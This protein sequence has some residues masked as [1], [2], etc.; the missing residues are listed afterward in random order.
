[1]TTFLAGTPSASWRLRAAG[2]TSPA[3]VRA[4]RPQLLG[5]E[6]RICGWMAR[7]R[8]SGEVVGVKKLQHYFTAPD[9]GAV[10]Q[11]P[12][13]MSSFAAFFSPPR[14]RSSLPQKP[15]SRKKQK[16]KRFASYDEIIR[17]KKKHFLFEHF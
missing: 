12:A 14:T 8:G 3:W 1:M 6:V 11:P 5:E 7:R 17:L 4:P 10:C 15:D 13:F 16:E 2:R 9:G